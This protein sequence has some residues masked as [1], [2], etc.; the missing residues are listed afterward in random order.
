MYYYNR[1]AFASSS[2][3]EE[4]FSIATSAATNGTEWPS[5][6]TPKKKF[7]FC[8]KK[9]SSI[10]L[11]WGPLSILQRKGF[12]GL[13][14]GLGLDDHGQVVVN[15]LFQPKGVAFGQGIPLIEN[16]QGSP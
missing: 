15:A 1:R 14:G 9:D 8:C 4:A 6:V 5:I 10:P 11:L 13:T 7:L 2:T 3:G 12:F 16:A